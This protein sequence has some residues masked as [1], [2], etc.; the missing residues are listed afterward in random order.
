V[1]G[2]TGRYDA[3]IARHPEL[4]D[5]RQ[6]VLEVG[7]GAESIA[8]YLER[9]V[10]GVDRAFPDPV[11]THLSAVRASILHL[12]FRDGGFDHVVC[13]DSL[14]QL[15]P[16]EYSRAIAEL[17]RVASK[18]II[19]AI[20]AGTFA[21]STD[22]AYAHQMARAGAAVPDWLRASLERG[23]PQLGDLFA[24]LLATGY[25]FTVHRSEGL[26][27]HYAGLFVDSAA[28]LGAFLR[29]HD[30]KF[31]GEAPLRAAEGDLPY[32]YLFAIDKTA[33][34]ASGRGNIHTLALA[35]PSFRGQLKPPRIAMFAVGHRVA[36]L[37]VFP[38]VRRI[39]AGTDTLV[40]SDPDVL[41][42]NVGAISPIG[43]TPTRR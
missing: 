5:A 25:A 17:V 4:F 23:I 6:R 36:R 15:A 28:F 12:P 30:L 13:G 14:L 40:I 24:A 10:V 34:P 1:I 41:R 27:Q 29:A 7:A 22:A 19:I 11:G 2:M 35:S 42:D 21:A 32:S 26:L 43:T 31:P 37:P 39:L 38:G 9:S 33:T 16:D 18:G 8:R 20:P 3:L